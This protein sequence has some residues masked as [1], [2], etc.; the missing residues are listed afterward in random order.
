MHVTAPAA[1]WKYQPRGS[2][3]WYILHAVH[4]EIDGFSKQRLLQLLDKNSFAANLHHGCMLRLVSGG[5]DDDDLRFHARP[6]E[7]LFPNEFRLPRRR[8]PAARADPQAP[9]S[10]SPSHSNTSRN[11]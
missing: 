7:S 11:P 5:L 6:R 9:P 1:R 4:G 3:G 8:Q 10:S 2:V